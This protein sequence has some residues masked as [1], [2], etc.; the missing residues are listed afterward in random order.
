MCHKPGLRE[1][2]S[3]PLAKDLCDPLA[4]ERCESDGHQDLAWP[5]ELGNH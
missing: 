2:P 1:T 4:A 3:P 5:Q